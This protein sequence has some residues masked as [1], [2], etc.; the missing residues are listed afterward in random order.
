M[1]QR[2]V[3]KDLLDSVDDYVV[4]LPPRVRHLVFLASSKAKEVQQ[5]AMPRPT[6]GSF[7]WLARNMK[8]EMESKYSYLF[9]LLVPTGPS[10]RRVYGLFVAETFDEMVESSAMP[11]EPSLGKRTAFIQINKV[12]TQESGV[13]QD[14]V[15]FSPTKPSAAHHDSLARKADGVGSFIQTG[16]RQKENS[17]EDNKWKSMLEVTEIGIAIRLIM[18]L[19]MAEE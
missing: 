16:I 2:T 18:S 4:Q 5:H 1:M 3:M 12:I 6:T 14:N 17:S 7:A 15:K 10:D 19:L 11:E 9:R 13:S 8:A